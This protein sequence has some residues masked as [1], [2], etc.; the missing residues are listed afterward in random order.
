[1]VH[2]C[3]G[4]IHLVLLSPA[5]SVLLLLIYSFAFAVP[6]G[7]TS[8]HLKHAFALPLQEWVNTHD[9][10]NSHRN[11]GDDL[12]PPQPTGTLFPVS[13]RLWIHAWASFN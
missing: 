10:C 11:S 5:S 9:P 6:F 4:K 1:M 3:L 7:L 2:L 8:G 13:P 12:P